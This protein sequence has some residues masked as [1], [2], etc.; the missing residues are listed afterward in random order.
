M[1]LLNPNDATWIGLAWLSAKLGAANDDT[2]SEKETSKWWQDKAEKAGKRARKAETGQ[3]DAL[4]RA[5]RA[6]RKAKRHLDLELKAESKETTERK[7]ELQAMAARRQA[8]VWATK[9]E[10]DAAAEKTEAELEAQR[11]DKHKKMLIFSQR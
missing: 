3:E 10:G 2:S 5:R 4:A 8:E 6:N 11:A 7:A 1:C 9:E